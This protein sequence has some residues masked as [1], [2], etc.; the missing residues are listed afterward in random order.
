MV[1]EKPVQTQ[2]V[3][4]L[5][6]L[7]ITAIA[8]M[9]LLHVSASQWSMVPLGGGAWRVFNAYDSLSRFCVPVLVMLSGVFFLDPGRS[10]PLK[11]L[12]TKNIARVVVAFGFWSA[13]YA[14]YGQYRSVVLQGQAFSA[15]VL[16]KNFLLGHYHL[17]F[18]YTL[19]G[20]YLAV[21]LLRKL[22]ESR[23]LTAYYLTL[24]FVLCPLAGAAK[25][26]APLRSTVQAVLTKLDANLFL[27]FAG[28][29][30]LGYF[31]YHTRLARRWRL[32]LYAAGAASVCFTAAATRWASVAAGEGVTRW[33]NYLLPN[34]LLPAAA[35]FV[36]FQYG[37]SRVEWSPAAQRAIGQVAGLSFG[38]YLVHDFVNRR[39]WELGL[40]TTCCSPVL[41]VPLVT[42]AVF[43]L[44]LGAAWLLGRVPLLRRW[45]M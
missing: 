34:N 15:R 32:L 16:L 6:L 8:F 28:Y 22:T 18:L 12:L 26:I 42:L 35:V 39:L 41:A 20:L 24:W 38:M 43:A 29:F 36:L 37:V 30:V 44:S 4:C 10:Q 9:M 3:V 7:R 11:K 5:D 2:R 19:V 33:Y 1:T 27:G 17:W 31:L 40:T 25:N 13:A 21:P 14:L 45:I 23:R